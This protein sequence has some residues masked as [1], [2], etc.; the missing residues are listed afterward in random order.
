MVP[1][2]QRGKGKLGEQNHRD[3]GLRELW[4]WCGSVF[5]VRCCRW[6][7]TCENPDTHVNSASDN[8][9]IVT[10]PKP[11]VTKNIPERTVV[12]KIYNYMDSLIDYFLVSH[13]PFFVK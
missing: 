9:M 7:A 1:G 10:S 8:E 5:P 6:S 12:I 13:I 11:P 2:N 3:V 4:A